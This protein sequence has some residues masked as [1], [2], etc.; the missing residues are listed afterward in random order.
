MISIVRVSS[1]TMPQAARPP[2][3]G[4]T[5]SSSARRGWVPPSVKRLIVVP[6]GPLHDSR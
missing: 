2:P 5:T 3:D 6:D 1:N 4:S